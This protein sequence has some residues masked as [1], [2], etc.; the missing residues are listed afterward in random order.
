LLEI[1]A[2]VVVCLFEYWC[3]HPTTLVLVYHQQA[4]EI[5]VLVVMPICLFVVCDVFGFNQSLFVVRCSL[6]FYFGGMR[7]LTKFDD[8]SFKTSTFT[9][10][11]KN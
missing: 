9:Q 10:V 6:V 2:V 4:F 3:S 11:A 7:H 1:V 8:T 5:P